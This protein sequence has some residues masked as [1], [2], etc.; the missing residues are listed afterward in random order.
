MTD[1]V[2]NEDR[3]LTFTV[4][5]IDQKT[6]IDALDWMETRQSGNFSL[7]HILNKINLLENFR[8]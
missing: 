3:T 4:Q 6:L 8:N 5:T 2:Q 1:K 7:S